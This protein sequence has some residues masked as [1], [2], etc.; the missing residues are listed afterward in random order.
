MAPFLVCTIEHRRTM[1]PN[2]PITSLHWPHCPF[3]W[4]KVPC[5]RERAIPKRSA[6]TG[7]QVIKGGGSL[8]AD[9]EQRTLHRSICIASEGRS[10][11]YQGPSDYHKRRS[12]C[13]RPTFVDE[14]QSAVISP[15]TFIAFMTGEEIGPV[16]PR[17]AVYLYE[18][19]AQICVDTPSRGNADRAPRRVNAA[20]TVETRPGV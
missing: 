11:W 14:L 15:Q 4:T 1:V 19:T 12:E 13:C 5:E 8:A 10:E 16:F 9:G 20:Q 17:S 3:T 18:S 7:G 6:S 2:C